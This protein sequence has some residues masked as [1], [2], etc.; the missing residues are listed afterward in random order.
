[1]PAPSRSSEPSVPNFRSYPLLPAPL[2][3]PQMQAPIPDMN[4]NIVQYQ[5]P[6]AQQN[7]SQITNVSQSAASDVLA[8]LQA[9]PIKEVEA[10]LSNQYRK[11][12]PDCSLLAYLRAPGDGITQAQAAALVL[13]ELADGIEDVSTTTSLVVRYVQAHRLWADHPNPAVNSLETLL[14]TIDGIQYVQAGT[15]IGT[16]SQLMRARAIR[17]IEKHWGADWFLKIPADMKDPAW[18]TA[19]DCSHQ[20]LR[21]IAANAKQGIDLEM[22][23]SAWAQ[24]IHRRRDERVRKELRMRCPRFPFIIT[25]DVRSLSQTLGLSRQDRRTSE[26][27]YPD[28]PAEDQLRVELVTPGSKRSAPFAQE[29]SANKS[30]Q[31]KRQ[32]RRQQDSRV[33]HPTHELPDHGDGWRVTNDGRWKQRRNGNQII[34]V[35][36]ADCDGSHPRTEL[37]SAESRAGTPH[38]ADGTVRSSA[39][40]ADRVLCNGPSIAAD[41]RR[42]IGTLA[43][44][45][46]DGSAS[47]KLAGCCCTPCRSKIDILDEMINGTIQVA[48]ALEELTDH[49]ISSG[50]SQHSDSVPSTPQLPR[51]YRWWLPIDDETDGE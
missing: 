21:L 36:L 9:L 51:Q 22:A 23:K 43:L 25:D 16:S 34:R 33:D 38:V 1:M 29:F 46:K 6:S 13:E 19:A 14:G 32:K 35:P 11:S 2:A 18:S 44:G 30:A 8:R 49:Q 48:T 40:S 50:D 10:T 7:P 41:L 4:G 27:V 42:I 3:L 15:V 26:I 17:L 47:S 24:S 12:D 28:E 5:P 37:L 20:L 31:R 39:R 45:G